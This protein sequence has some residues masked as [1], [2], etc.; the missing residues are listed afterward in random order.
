L[1]LT[2]IKLYSAQAKLT[3]RETVTKY[4][5][6]YVPKEVADNLYLYYGLTILGIRIIILVTDLTIKKYTSSNIEK[7]TEVEPALQQ[8]VDLK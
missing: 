5:I 1:V 3:W 8:I 6:D 2:T 4:R 7:K